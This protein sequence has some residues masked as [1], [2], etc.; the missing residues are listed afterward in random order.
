MFKKN[1][2]EKNEEIEALKRQVENL[3]RDLQYAYKQQHEANQKIEAILRAMNSY[4]KE[5]VVMK[6]FIVEK[7]N[8]SGFEPVSGAISDLKKRVL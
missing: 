2:V 8:D 5:E 1:K 4:I 3:Q 6:S 7:Y